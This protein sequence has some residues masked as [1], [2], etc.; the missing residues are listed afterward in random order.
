M[1]LRL[2]AYLIVAAVALATGWLVRGWKEDSESY[3]VASAAQAIRDDALAREWTIAGKVE[4]RLAELKANQTV[5]DRGII[6]EIQNPIY[7]NVCFGNDLVRLFNDAAAGRAT[8]DAAKPAGE[9]PG[10]PVSAQ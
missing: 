8:S 4:K 5:I 1:T 3:A 2:A 9:V 7:R 10:K 6:R